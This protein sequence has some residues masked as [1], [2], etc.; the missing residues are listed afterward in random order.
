VSEA[1]DEKNSVLGIK[2]Q[3]SAAVRGAR[4]GCAPLDPLVLSREVI[5]AG[6]LSKYVYGQYFYT[7]M[8]NANSVMYHEPKH[9]LYNNYI[10][11]YI[12]SL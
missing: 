7:F 4:A 9:E 8:Y 6:S 1:S 5:T 10:Q 3:R 12:L 11:H 2:N